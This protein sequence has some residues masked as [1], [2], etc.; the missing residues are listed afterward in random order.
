M[1]CSEFTF[2]AAHG[3]FAAGLELLHLATLLHHCHD[4]NTTCLRTTFCLRPRL[5]RSLTAVQLLLVPSSIAI[6][7]P[8]LCDGL[9]YRCTLCFTCDLDPSSYHDNQLTSLPKISAPRSPHLAGA[10][11]QRKGRPVRINVCS[12]EN[13]TGGCF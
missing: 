10:R 8:F 4:N 1:S 12:A 2:T 13:S 5:D 9:P 6:Q 7:H 3:P 11:C